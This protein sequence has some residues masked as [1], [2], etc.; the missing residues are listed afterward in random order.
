MAVSGH[1][2]IIFTFFCFEWQ[3]PTVK[4][5]SFTFAFMSAIVV[6]AI[7]TIAGKWF[8]YD[9]YDRRGH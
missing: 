6:A 7:F 8:P 9:R 2:Q 3:F 5:T 1:E 4:Q